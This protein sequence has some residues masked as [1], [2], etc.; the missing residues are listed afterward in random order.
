MSCLSAYH[1]ELAAEMRRRILVA[2]SR[3]VAGG[4]GEGEEKE[5]LGI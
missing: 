2:Q 3:G 1:L 5:S 4:G